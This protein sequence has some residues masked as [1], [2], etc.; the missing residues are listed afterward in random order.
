MSDCIL[1]F[2]TITFDISDP[3]ITK[4]TVIVKQVGGDCGTLIKSR[5]ENKFPARLSM[6]DIIQQELPKYLEW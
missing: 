4:V 3:D 6:I 5:Y 2:Q 1:E